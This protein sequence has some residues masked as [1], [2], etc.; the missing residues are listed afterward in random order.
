MNSPDPL[1]PLLS[2]WTP[3]R[4]SPGLKRRLFGTAAA[5]LSPAAWLQFAPPAFAA[6]ALTVTLT[7]HPNRL[8]SSIRDL[9]YST[10]LALGAAHHSAAFQ[11]AHN[12]LSAAS[13]TWTNAA[14]APSTNASFGGL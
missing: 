12:S 13:F 6:V 10:N 1:E 2:A 14:L 4:P 3:R 7:L 9:G 5:T 8:E 11:S